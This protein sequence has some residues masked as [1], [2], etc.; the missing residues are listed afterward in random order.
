MFGYTPKELVVEA[1]EQIDQ[2]DEFFH[3]VDTP[4]VTPDDFIWPTDPLF[5]LAC[6][7]TVHFIN[8]FRQCFHH[9]LAFAQLK[10]IAG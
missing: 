6:V 2:W 1:L 4:P 7:T 3:Y 8:S 9:P 10:R 5:C